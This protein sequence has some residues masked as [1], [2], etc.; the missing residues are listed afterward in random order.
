[1]AVA[2]IIAATATRSDSSGVVWGERIEIASGS[3][4][5]GPWLMNESDFRYLDD[6]TVFVD[7]TGNCAVAWVDQSRKDVFFQVYDPGGR[8][9]FPEPVNVSRTP[10]IFS[11]LPRL[12]VA[13]GAPGRVYVLWQEIVFSGGTHG[14][15]IFFARS[16]DGGR[17]FEDP[18]NLSTSIAGDGKG[19]LTA[20]HWHNGSLDLALG[21]DGMLYATWTEYE[22]VLWFS[23]S[24]N[25]GESFFRPRRIAG[26][27]SLPA[28]GPSLAAG[29]DSTVYIAWSIGED[30]GADIRFARSLDAGRSFEAPRIVP[31]G[32]GHCDAPR[33][34]VDGERT[35]HL[36]YA[37]SPEGRSRR[38]RVMYTRTKDGG[39]TFERPREISRD[40]EVP[41]GASFPALSVDGRDAL[42][43]TWERFPRDSPR[44]LGLGF[45]HS[46]DGG[47]TFSAVSPLPGSVD[48]RG[49]NGSRQ[50]LLMRKLAVNEAGSIAV[51]NSTFRTRTSHVWLIRGRHE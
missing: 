48:P 19:R 13:P 37:E 6:P 24:T 2:L 12:I 31:F 3:S 30:A 4:H 35:L 20:S 8:K 1:V 41:A 10:G 5:K 25:G 51:V 7:A 16:N 22:G 18:L 47:R 26:N 40:R 17:S 39:H 29:P 49:Y 21:S 34:A 15:E 32:A 43:L 44:P 46:N 27:H 14:G 42:Y 50:G 45:A 9:R 38:Y 23:R 28:R 33:L 11:W 36:V